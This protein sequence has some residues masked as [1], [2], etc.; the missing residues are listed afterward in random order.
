MRLIT[1]NSDGDAGEAPDV[2]DEQVQ[3]RDD[4][5]GDDDHEDDDRRDAH[6][7]VHAVGE[8]GLPPA[9]EHARH[10]RERAR[11]RT[12]RDLA[13]C[14][15]SSS[16]SGRK[17]ED[18]EV[19]DERQRDDGEHRV[20]RGER[21]VERDIAAEEVAVEVRRRAARRRREQHHA[22]REHRRQL[23]QQHEAEADRGQQHELADEGDDHRLR[24]LRHAREVA[25]REGE[26]EPEHDDAERDGQS[27]GGQR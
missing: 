15:P 12:P 18:R 23:E 1:Q 27:D 9:H 6:G 16:S 4:R 13:N 2:L 25:R 5:A 10:H 19:G 14:R 26:A 20:D 7:L 24:M 22:D 21:D 3:V 17:Y 8:P 11:S